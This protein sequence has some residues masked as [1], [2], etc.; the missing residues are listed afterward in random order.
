MC[1]AAQ[2]SITGNNYQEKMRYWATELYDK[3]GNSQLIEYHRAFRNN[4]EEE[5]PLGK[6]IMWSQTQREA[7]SRRPAQRDWRGSH[8][9]ADGGQLPL[10]HRNNA[11]LLPGCSLRRKW[12]TP[13]M[14]D[15]IKNMSLKNDCFWGRQATDLRTA[16]A[17][18]PG[19]ARTTCGLT[20]PPILPPRP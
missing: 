19:P 18:G 10:A 6:W 4:R 7:R 2:H 17:S 8:R 14:T 12:N 15:P 13:K 11:E 5:K 16:L 9:P 20:P 3:P 1:R